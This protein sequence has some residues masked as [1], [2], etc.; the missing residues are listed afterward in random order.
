MSD[1]VML[2]LALLLAGPIV[3]ILQWCLDRLSDIWQWYVGPW[4]LDLWERMEHHIHT[5]R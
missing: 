5:R 4:L 3:A 1:I 2:L